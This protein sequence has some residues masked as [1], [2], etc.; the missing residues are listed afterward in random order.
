MSN[1]NPKLPEGES[2]MTTKRPPSKDKKSNWVVIEDAANSWIKGRVL[3]GNWMVEEALREDSFYITYKDAFKGG[4]EWAIVYCGF[5]EPKSQRIFDI[6]TGLMLVTFMA[7][8][9]VGLGIVALNIL[10][11]VLSLWKEIIG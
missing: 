1:D 5:P 7:G 6:I 9:V 10:W 11:S 4:A 3:R 2:E 8:A